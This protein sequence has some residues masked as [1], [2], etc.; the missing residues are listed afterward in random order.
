MSKAH[1]V[2]TGWLDT[3]LGWACEALAV[4][5]YICWVLP[6]TAWLRMTGHIPRNKE[7]KW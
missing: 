2:F 3:L 5:T 1:R 4:A 6:K 7:G